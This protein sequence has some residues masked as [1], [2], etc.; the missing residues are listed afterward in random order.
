MTIKV[1]GIDR[2]VNRDLRTDEK[3]GEGSERR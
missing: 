1:S 2:A 3:E